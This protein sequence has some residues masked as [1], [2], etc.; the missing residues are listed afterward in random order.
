MEKSGKIQLS[1]EELDSIRQGV[2]PRRISI[3]WGLTLEDAINMVN[4]GCYQITAC[5]F[6]STQGSVKK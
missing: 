4:Q 1:Q 5:F 6:A 3:E 2:L